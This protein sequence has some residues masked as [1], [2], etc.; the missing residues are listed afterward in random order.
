MS[1]YRTAYAPEFHHHFEVV[2]GDDSAPCIGRCEQAPAAV[3][4]QYPVPFARWK[5]YFMH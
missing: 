2:T 3:M 5:P 4:H 1:K